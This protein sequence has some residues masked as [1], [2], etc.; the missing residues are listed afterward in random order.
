MTDSGSGRRRAVADIAKVVFLLS[1]VVGV[2]L[3]A[4]AGWGLLQARSQQAA[5]GPDVPL[6][7]NRGVVVMT[8][9]SERTVYVDGPSLEQARCTA[10]A[11]DGTVQT[12]EGFDPVGAPPLGKRAL[13][14]ITASQGGDYL[15]ECT[16]VQ[17]SSVS[18]G[19]GPGSRAMLTI[20][21]LA[22]L[23]LAAGAVPVGAISLVVWR[24][25]RRA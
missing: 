22:G 15:V 24:V 12:L 13:G 1:L 14:E 2:L 9:D 20:A 17:E 4:V 10:T 6:A 3:A 23:L 8:E 11:P 19:S 21:G 7:D 18:G 25:A 5:T 16:G